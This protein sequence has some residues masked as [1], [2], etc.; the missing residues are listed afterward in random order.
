M[1][2][3]LLR[4]HWERVARME[5]GGKEIRIG[6][7]GHQVVFHTPDALIRAMGASILDD[8]G[9]IVGTQH[10]PDQ[11]G[12]LVSECMSLLLAVRLAEVGVGT[13]V[14]MEGASGD[15]GDRW[16]VQGCGAVHTEN[17]V[18]GMS[19]RRV[20]ERA[21]WVTGERPED[22][23]GVS[24]DD[25]EQACRAVNRNFELC[26]VDLGCVAVMEM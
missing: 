14:G 21:M 16:V 2:A 13:R 15:V 9:M 11:V 22:E 4:L 25:V 12:G 10:D 18:A 7:P 20:L 19:V 6:R 23:G 1:G 24:R 3:E 17:R 26:Q 8:D 5:T